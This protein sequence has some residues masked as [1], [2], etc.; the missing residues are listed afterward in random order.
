VDLLAAVI[1]LFAVKILHKMA[2]EEH[3]VH[4][5]IENISGTVEALLKSFW[6]RGWIIYEAATSSL[7]PQSRSRPR[8]GRGSDA[9]LF[10]H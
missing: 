7:R 9:R 5:K 3:P 4:G 1:A 10:R 8:V 2:D 6:S